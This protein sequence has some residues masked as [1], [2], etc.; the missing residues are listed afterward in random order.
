MTLQSESIV[1]L[2]DRFTYSKRKGKSPCK[3]ET[4]LRLVLESI[5]EGVCGVDID[6]RNVFI[7]TAGL[8]LLGYSNASELLGRSMHRL[9]HHTCYNGSPCLEERCRIQRAIREGKTFHIEDELLWRRDGSSFHAE[10]RSSPIRENEKILG[11]VVSF[12]DITERLRADRE[13]RS[14]AMGLNAVG[15]SI[16]M[17]EKDGTI[18]Y[19]N[20]AFTRLTGYSSDEVVGK[21]PRIWSSGKQT[22]AFYRQLWTTVQSGEIWSGDLKNRRKDGSLYSAEL[23]VAPIYDNDGGIEGY[24]GIEND[25]TERERA[26]QALYEEKERAEITLHSIGDGV[27]TTNDHGIVEQMNVRAEVLSC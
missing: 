10:Y 5:G 1:S 15:E 3:D 20:P 7:N 27:I 11:A 24:V 21:T 19:V 26:E 4:V 2:S 12:R 18:R 23:T 6:G 22:S 16:M 25:I 13:I 8:R 14:L 9:I 17:T